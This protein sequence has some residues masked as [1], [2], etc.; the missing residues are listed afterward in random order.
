MANHPSGCALEDPATGA[1]PH[2]AEHNRAARRNGGL[3]I[4]PSPLIKQRKK[5][6]KRQRL[7][8]KVPI[9]FPGGHSHPAHVWGDGLTTPEAVVGC[10]SLPAQVS[11]PV[12]RLFVRIRRSNLG[13]RWCCPDNQREYRRSP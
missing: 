12:M 11:Q 3:T 10:I 9:P 4:T 5:T 6:T 1:A 13:A 7:N 8:G 2:R